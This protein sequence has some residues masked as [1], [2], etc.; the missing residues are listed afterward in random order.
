MLAFSEEPLRD[1]QA[2]T[3][4]CVAAVALIVNVEQ[5]VALMQ[6]GSLRSPPQV[7]LLLQLRLVACPYR[8]GLEL[9]VK[10]S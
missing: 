9:P 2:L 3:V 6:G 1:Y 5:V 10:L 8:A 4:F 7:F